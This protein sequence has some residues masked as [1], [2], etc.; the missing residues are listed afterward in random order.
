[1]NSIIERVIEDPL[2]FFKLRVEYQLPEVCIAAVS[3]NEHAGVHVMNM[4][5]VLHNPALLLAAVK[6]DADGKVFKW[7]RATS[8]SRRPTDICLA[9]FERDY[10]EYMYMSFNE[11]KSIINDAVR[12]NGNVIQ[13]VQR[14]KEHK[15]QMV[16]GS[17]IRAFTIVEVPREK[18]LCLD[19]VSAPGCGPCI[20]YLHDD[21]ID[22]EICIAAVKNNAS[23]SAD[24]GALALQYIHHK[25]R[26]ENVCATA[27]EH[28]LLDAYKL[29]NDEQKEFP[30]VKSLIASMNT[31]TRMNA[32]ASM[33]TN[34]SMNAN[35]NTSMNTN[36]SMNANMDKINLDYLQLYRKDIYTIASMPKEMLTDEFIIDALTINGYGIQ[37]IPRQVD[38][39]ELPRNPKYCLAAVSSP[40]CGPC[41][42]HLFNDE[43]TEEIC[44]S[45]VKNNDINDLSIGYINDTHRTPLVCV[46]AIMH[47][48]ASNP[49]DAEKITQLRSLLTQEQLCQKIII[50]L[51]QLCSICL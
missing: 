49:N 38:N 24:V 45:A 28:S 27:V 7:L 16:N 9:A 39:G 51:E 14:S 25:F 5:S 19:A 35:A 37:Y 31:N 33:N 23:V 48:H 32:N 36:A 15:T 12:I 46:T 10:R 1:M 42:Q 47:L 3:A 13:Y 8:N 20:Q 18:R 21:E 44:I 11:Q 4:R 50:S 41:I 17:Y 22:E 34:T 2:E 43:I 26:T 29:L 6:H 40:Q 30:K